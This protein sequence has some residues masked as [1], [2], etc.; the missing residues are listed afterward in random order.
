MPA[1]KWVTTM[2]DIA[3]KVKVLGFLQGDVP[4]V[5]R[6]FAELAAAAACTEAQIVEVVRDLKDS[7]VIRR[8]GAVLRHQKAGYTANALVA[9]Q[10]P[11]GMEDVVGEQMASYQQVSHCYH[12]QVPDDFPFQLFTMMHAHNANEMMELV[13]TIAGDTGMTHFLMLP[14]VREFKKVS[15]RYDINSIFEVGDKGDDNG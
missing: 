6:P 1:F 12:R 9:W 3:L 7:G 5:K 15:M 8:Y 2:T 14:S 13:K 4:S 10:V 11:A